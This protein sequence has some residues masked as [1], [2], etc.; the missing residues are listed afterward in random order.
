MAMELLLTSRQKPTFY[1]IGVTTG[2]SSINAI[3]PKWMRL[4]RLEVELAGLDIPLHAPAA[5]YRQVIAHMRHDPLV[6]GGLVTTHKL[7][8]LEATRDLFDSLDSHAQLCGEVSA[9]VRR[10]E[11]LEGYA[12]DPIASGLSWRTFVPDKHF[13][14]RQAEVLCFGCGGAAVATTVFLANQP[15]K[16]DRPWRVTLVD[17]NSARLEYAR[18]VHARLNT[19]IVFEYV[20]NENPAENDR[21]L[22]ALAPGSVVINASGMGKDVPGSPVTDA[23]FFPEHGLVWDFNYRGELTFLQQARQQAAARH[24]TIEDGRVYFLHGWTQA[25]AVVF[26]LHLTPELFARLAETAQPI[27]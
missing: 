21:R 17:I 3:F 10:G 19:D 7:D 5:V 16:S 15:E 25:L 20:L 22:A 6:R 26:Q 27:G 4:L 2:K 12:R 18:A 24:L 11:R 13:G 1:F 14:H 9:I 8:L 23:G